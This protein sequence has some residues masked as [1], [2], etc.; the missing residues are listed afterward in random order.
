MPSKSRQSQDGSG[1]RRDEPRETGGNG[2]PGEGAPAD[3]PARKARP[4]LALI[5]LLCAVLLVILGAIIW[6]ETRPKLQQGGTAAIGG[7]FRLIDQDGRAVDQHILDGK[8]TAVFFG[9]TY[10]PDTCPA[11]L[12][13]LAAAADRLGPRAKDFQ[14]ALVTVDPQRD[15]PAQLKQ[16]L[17]NQGF[18]K[19]AW[20]LTGT[21]AQ[22]AQVAKAYKVYY[23]RNGEGDDYLMDHTAVIYLMNPKGGFSR[24]LSEAMKPDLISRQIGDAMAGRD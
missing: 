24:G 7:P 18:P 13:T 4:G 11:T 17:S 19:K 21:P 16:Y 15:T 23:A 8:W 1:P 9:Y 2:R 22:I 5:V 3:G 14:V 20:G 6:V 10:C 12:Q